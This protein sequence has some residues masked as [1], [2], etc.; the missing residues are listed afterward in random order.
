MRLE[1]ATS[2]TLRNMLTIGCRALH[3]AGHGNCTQ[4]YLEDGCA[5]VHPVA[6]ENL[7]SL[8]AAGGK[9]RIRLAFVS[10]CSSAPVG[11]LSLCNFYKE[12]LQFV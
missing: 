12:I 5:G 6:H 2:D 4:L 10:A 8:L 3:F 7:A 9:T 11:K 1:F